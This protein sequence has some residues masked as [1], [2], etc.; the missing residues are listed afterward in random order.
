[1]V[2]LPI[3]DSLESRWSHGSLGTRLLLLAV[4][5]GFT[6]I[7]SLILALHMHTPLQARFQLAVDILLITWLIW[8]TDVIH[9]PYIAL[10]IVSS[11]ISSLFLGP[12]IP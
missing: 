11:L 8:T 1:M 7:Y 4:V 5:A 9:S 6:V 3:L 2:L 10:Y 12:E